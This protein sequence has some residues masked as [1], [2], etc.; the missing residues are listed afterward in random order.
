MA[1]LL[2]GLRGEPVKR[3][4]A[5]LG[6]EADG[7]FGPG[8][9]KALKDYQKSKGLTV[10]GIAGPDTF[11]SMGLTELILLQRGSRGDTVKKLQQALS[12]PAD[13]KFGPA[14]EKAVKEFQQKNGLKADGL[15]GPQTLAK[16]NLF[17]ITS[18]SV[19]ASITEA[20]Q[21][22]WDTIE[23]A[24]DGALKKVKSFL[25]M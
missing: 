17:G 1:I 15:A 3:L 23:E 10:D 8:T 14:T 6:V 5:K 18:K 2:R 24:A 12:I 13:G 11:S 21:S 9:E 25:G 7:V 19:A 4:Q 20:G 22:V 16:L